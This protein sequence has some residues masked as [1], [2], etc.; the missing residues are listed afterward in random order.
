MITHELADPIVETRSA[1]LYPPVKS[2]T[3][4]PATLFTDGEWQRV[5]RPGGLRRFGF[6]LLCGCR[7]SSGRVGLQLRRVV[8]E[9]GDDDEREQ[10]T[11]P[12]RSG[13][14]CHKID[15]GPPLILV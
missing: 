4:D 5:K 12:Q 9:A 3:A 7:A 8:P 11:D 10:Y 1:E 2:R 6:G 14:V 15:S 13:F